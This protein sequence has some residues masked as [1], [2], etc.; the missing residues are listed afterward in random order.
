MLSLLDSTCTCYAPSCNF[1]S[2]TFNKLHLYP[3]VL[4]WILPSGTQRIWKA[5]DHRLHALLLLTKAKRICTCLLSSFL[6]PSHSSKLS[7]LPHSILPTHTYGLH[8]LPA[9]SPP[10]LPCFFLGT[11]LPL[12]WRKSLWPPYK[13]ALSASE[14]PH[15]NNDI[16]CMLSC[17]SLSVQ[18]SVCGRKSSSS[19]SDYCLVSMCHVLRISHMNCF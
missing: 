19:Y 3:H 2:L 16:S 8:C 18:Y 6:W 7:F 12:H 15:R 4:L 1:P 14:L 5:S 11:I 13:A 9:P 10:C 17:L